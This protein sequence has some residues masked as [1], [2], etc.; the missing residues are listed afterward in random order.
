MKNLLLL[1][2]LA[3]LL[4]SAQ[5]RSNRKTIKQSLSTK[6]L[7]DSDFIIQ[8]RYYSFSYLA[9]QKGD[10]RV[11]HDGKKRSNR[12]LVMA[13]KAFKNKI[14]NKFPV[15]TKNSKSSSRRR[16]SFS[17]NKAARYDLDSE[18]L[19]N[20]LSRKKKYEV[21]NTDNPSLRESDFSGTT[22]NLYYNRVPFTGI[23]YDSYNN[24]AV[25]NEARYRNGVK[26]GLCSSWYENGKIR[27]KKYYLNGQINIPS[28]SWY[29]N[30]KR[31]SEIIRISSQFCFDST[32]LN[33]G[34]ITASDENIPL[35]LSVDD[36]TKVDLYDQPLPYY[37]SLR[38][39]SLIDQSDDKMKEI[40]NMKFQINDL[41]D[42]HMVLILEYNNLID[43]L[44]DQEI[45]MCRYINNIK[46]VE[47]FKIF[48]KYHKKGKLRNKKMKIYTGYHN[49]RNMIEKIEKLISLKI[50]QIE[51]NNY[52]TIIYSEDLV[53]LEKELKYFEKMIKQE[54]RFEIYKV[55]RQYTYWYENGLIFKKGMVCNQKSHGLYQT[56]NE[57]GQKI[58]QGYYTQGL[59]DG[60]WEEWYE[61]GQIS[62][63][64]IYTS[65]NESGLCEDWHE[66]GKRA[67]IRSYNIE[68]KKN[69]EAKYWHDNGRK[70][71][72]GDYID[73]ERDGVWNWWYEN[74]QLELRCSYEKGKRINT[75]QDKRYNED[76]SVQKPTPTYS[77][78]YCGKSY[79]GRGYT[80][81]MR[82][83]NRVDDEYSA[84]NSYC[85]SSCA[86][87]CILVEC[88]TW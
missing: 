69:G 70:K 71:I 51:N 40:L 59:K 29:E 87:A 86:T 28:K 65:G 14:L 55:N 77:C 79:T 75:N 67:S 44:L 11:Q 18:L 37:D 83:V 45:V 46:Q 39:E 20:K 30:G 85:S 74:G 9:H 48:A 10:D 82:V 62:T 25:K 54:Q 78:G 60:L 80:T 76:G 49:N 52:Q 38:H 27:F 84:L 19:I 2:L 63:K 31:E 73:N 6:E 13:E 81:I 23:I 32:I 53:D 4:L 47:L 3:P 12:Y 33:L 22:N 41:L 36:F 88:F 34:K 26:E 72:V 42:N 64:Y 21:A 15:K 50:N 17:N 5:K 57:A 7:T 61:D 66:N 68:G 1:L 43:E 8:K 24:G 56:W 35:N 58:K 16:P